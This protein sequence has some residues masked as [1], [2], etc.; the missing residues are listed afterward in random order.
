MGLCRG[1]MTSWPSFM[2]GA[3]S[4]FSPRVFPVTVM[5]LP[6]M[7]LFLSRYLQTAVDE[8]GSFSFSLDSDRRAM[9]DQEVL[10]SCAR[11][12]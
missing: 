6:S 3:L 7:R 12:P 1:R 4:R 11:P 9:T 8:Q 5:M 10:R 2:S